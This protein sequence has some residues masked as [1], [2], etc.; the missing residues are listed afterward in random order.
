MR[1]L[2]ALISSIL[3]G[4]VLIAVL[5]YPFEGR[6]GIG[7]LLDPWDGLYRTARST[8]GS[9]GESV[10]LGDLQQTVKVFRDARGVP[11][12]YASSDRDAVIALGFVAAQDRL[13]QMDFITRVASGKLSEVMGAGA[14]RTDRFMRSIG[15]DWGARR[16]ADRIEGAA[17]IELDLVRW[18][19]AGVNS[20]I[21]T[22]EDRDLPIEFRLLGY[23]PEKCSTMQVARV[24]QFMT[25]DLTFRTDDARYGSLKRV[26]APDDYAELFPAYA[27]INEPIIPTESVA[28]RSEVSRE[29]AN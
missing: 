25:Y 6:P 5:S 26:R 15:M 16:N 27:T 10:L 17:G 1:T 8:D 19:C 4:V 28:N 29:S 2:I 22:L 7:T 9:L 11:H 18:Y 23:R 12:I 13:F 24:L 20:Y 14:L 3:G 21:D